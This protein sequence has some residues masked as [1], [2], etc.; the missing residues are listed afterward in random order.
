MGVHSSITP[1]LYDLGDEFGSYIGFNGETLA[2]SSPKRDDAGPSSGAAFIFE[3]VETEDGALWVE[4]KKLFPSDISAVD[5]FGSIVEVSGEYIAASSPLKGNLDGAVYIFETIDRTLHANLAGYPVVGNAPLTVQF[6]EI[7]QRYPTSWQWDFD[8]DGV[9]DSEEQYPE[10]S[11]NFE[12]E[13]TVTL[14]V[15]DGESTSTFSKENYIKVTGGLLYGDIDQNGEVNILDII[16]A[17]DFVLGNTI[18]SA[19]QLEAGDMNNSGS[20]DIIDLVLIIDV[21]LER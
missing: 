14:T 19:D 18:P 5:I 16:N 15:G 3:L 2:I 11:Y 13:F 7:A 6:R 10:H 4:Y 12:G 9:I 20:I 8:N 21:I 1:S 17:V